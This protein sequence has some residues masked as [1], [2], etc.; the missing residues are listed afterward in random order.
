MAPHDGPRGRPGSKADRRSWATFR[1]SVVRATESWRLE[2][3]DAPV[4]AL[5]DPILRSVIV[6]FAAESLAQLH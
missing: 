2:T 5:H 6:T 4:G 3:C 1:L